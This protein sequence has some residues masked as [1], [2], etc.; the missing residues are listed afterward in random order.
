MV[1]VERKRSLAEVLTEWSK[2]G[3][4]RERQKW[5]QYWRSIELQIPLACQREVLNNDSR[6]GSIIPNQAKLS[7]METER[8]RKQRRRRKH[9]GRK[10]SRS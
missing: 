1:V 5:F 10:H 7:R 3:V 8:R 4:Q 9:K 2:E 6:V